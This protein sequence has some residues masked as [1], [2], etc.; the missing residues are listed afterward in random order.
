MTS[1]LVLARTPDIVI[2][3]P[4]IQAFRTGCLMNVDIAMRRHTMSAA[5]RSVPYWPDSAQGE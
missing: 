2:T 4:T 3:L 5:E 1:G